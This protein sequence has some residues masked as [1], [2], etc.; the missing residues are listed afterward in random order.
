MKVFRVVPVLAVLGM[1]LLVPAAAIA[2]SAGGP[3]IATTEPATAI[4]LTSATLNGTVSP[5]KQS[6]TFVFDYGTTKS[7]GLTAGQ[8]TASGNAGKPAMA[9]IGAL[10]PNTLYHFRLVAKNAS[11]TSTGQDMTF[12]TL[13]IGVPP[14]PAKD[15]VSIAVAPGMVTFGHSAVIS[16]RVT[17]PKSGGVQVVLQAQ[18]FPFTGPFKATG[19]VTTAGPDGRYSFA[20][21][22]R[23][24]THYLVVA[25][26]APPVT[27]TPV[28]VKVRY[29]VSFFVSSSLVNRGTLVRFF[30]SVRPAHNGRTVFI[31]RRSST[32]VYHTVATTV[33]RSTTSSTRSSYSKRLRI[34]G[35]GVYRVRILHDADHATNNSRA[36][37][38]TVR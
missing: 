27:S 35:S 37:R 38:I 33:L 9:T 5:N 2:T 8:G 26:T 22:P 24:L 3:P 29:A 4:T 19:A 16:G 12:T 34:F 25:K 36:R 23:L 7:Y 13:P 17:G 28:A 6:T 10:T 31:Q 1:L 11:G 14:L 20:V 15:A 30:G 32:G 18:P 21:A